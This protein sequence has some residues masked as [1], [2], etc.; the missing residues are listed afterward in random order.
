MR[1]GE[2]KVEVTMSVALALLL[3][4]TMAVPSELPYFPGS[5]FDST[6]KEYLQQRALRSWPNPAAQIE[7]WRSGELDEPRRVA[8]LLGGA[9]FHDPVLLP[10]YVEALGS[11]SGRVR[12]A[13]L[14][15]YR[16]LIADVPPDVSQGVSR[17][18]AERVIGEIRA[19][20]RTL[21]R[22]ALVDVWLESAL[23]AEGTR[24]RWR[25]I[26]LERPVPACLNSAAELA[27]PGDLPE[28]VEAYWRARELQTRIQL[29]QLAESLALQRFLVLPTGGRG[30]WTQ[31]VYEDALTRFDAWIATTCDLDDTDAVLTAGLQNLGLQ[32]EAP[33]SRAACGS[34]V[35]VLER[36]DPGWW[37]TAAKQL[38]DCGAPYVALEVLRAGGEPNR[39]RREILLG[40]LHDRRQ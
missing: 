35:A 31:N 13:A 10:A 15:G 32:V 34:W 36:G 40:W 25:G 12:Q 28:V 18:Q 7:A 3:G 27:R 11:D 23:A 16:D 5:Y 6:A 39:K 20:Q 37:A 29:M 22:H 21:R 38:Y 19:L 26:L 8:L 17:E 1:G 4:W 24:G 33:L 2:R 30:V 14:Y 9:A